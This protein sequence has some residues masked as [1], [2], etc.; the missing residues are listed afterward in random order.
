[1]KEQVRQIIL[2]IFISASNLVYGQQSTRLNGGWEFVRQDLG[3]VWEAV[4]PV[5]AGNPEELPF[6]HQVTLPHCFNATDAVDPDVNYYQ[7]PGWYRT[8]LDINNPYQNGHTL[9]HFEG[10][11]QKTSV[12][13]YTTKVAT[14]VGGYDEWTAD[15]TDAVAQF[16]KNPLF[17]TQFKNR[18]PIIVR[19]DNSRDL[20]MIPSN[21]SDFNVYGG[22]YRYLNLLYTPKVSFDKLFLTATINQTNHTG[23]LKVAARLHHFD[24]TIV[25]A[26]LKINIIDPKGLIVYRLTKSVKTFSNDS[27]LLNLTL[28]SPKLWSNEQPELYTVDAELIADGENASIKQKVGF[29]SFEFVKKGPFTLNGKR[30]LLRGTH[31]HEDHADVGA[32]MTEEMMLT[33]MK[34]MKEMGVNFIRL[35]HYQQ[36]RIILNA[37]DSLGILVWEEIPWCRGGLGGQVYQDQAKQMLTNM[38][39][40][41]YNHPS[42]IIWGLGNENDWPGDFEEF[43]Q[44]KIRAFM[45]E[46]NTLSHHL[47][48][49]RNTAIRRCDF[50]KDIV[51]VYSPSIW[52]GWYRGDYT[53]YKDVS[54]AEFN[55][56][57]RFLHV[58]WGGDSH[59]GRHSENPD[60]ALSQIKKGGGADERA[61][62]A[63]LYGGA[64]RVSKDGDWSESYIV[65]LIDWH[66]KE[67]ENMP[68]LSGSAYWPFKDFSTPIRP[69]NPVPYVNQ[70]GVIERDFTKKEAYFVFQSY[71]TEKPMVH[72][73]GHSWPTR[74][75]DDG[76]QKMVKVYSNCDEAEL[77]LNGKS[78]GVKQR[79]S[80]DFPAAGLRWQVPMFKGLQTFKVVARK[81]K[82]VV[83]DQ[84]TQ[85]YQTEKWGKPVKMS[86][87]KITE[88]G[89]IATVEVNA[90]DDQDVLC[91]DA[92]N[93]VSFQLIG[94]GEL[95]VNQGTSSGSSKVQLYNGRAIIKVKTNQANS[96]ISV[97]SKGIPTSFL[98][99][100]Q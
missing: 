48:P 75:G 60:K 38:I 59:A 84:I 57:D 98:N 56:T 1:M 96:V 10:A 29:R 51:D 89:G 40:Q 55:K 30:L 19:C 70:K 3:G 22:I 76:E 36:S 26:Q 67:Q 58:E 100:S 37:C 33:E 47:D 63:S 83:T 65:N 39:E 21:L 31:R 88:S 54:L 35:G 86:I 91:L 42:I 18:V 64:A 17:K 8:Y 66:L 99:L 9:L 82:T 11:G 49:L 95:I 69:D 77:F 23:T 2:I 62:D 81:N 61:G 25:S 79:N 27:V 97:Q 93:V 5:K 16:K 6:W 53:E 32:A 14:H 80:Q 72:I 24:N 44:N 20:E 78:L 87:K 4:R 68:W 7:G 12:Y 74:W 45:M 28:K 92:Q 15:I 94:D 13:V 46:L 90:L 50:C 43:D 71:W 34:L 73:Y 52:A 41:H 85:V